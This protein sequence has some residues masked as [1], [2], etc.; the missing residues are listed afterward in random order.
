MNKPVLINIVSGKGGTGKSLLSALLARMIAQEGAKVLL[1]DF[2]LFVRGLSHFYYLFVKEKR[3]ITNKKTISDYYEISSNSTNIESEDFAKERFYEVDILPAVSEIEEQLDYLEIE[4][5][6]VEK[7][8]R[9]L[10]IL[11][12]EPYDYVIIDNR[13]GVDE[14][15]LETSRISELTITV[16]ESDPISKTTNENLLRHLSSHKVGKVYTIINKMKFIR[17]VEEYETSIE[18]IRSDFNVI[19][20]IPFDV[21]LFEKFGTTRFWDIAN[22]T[23]YAYALGETWNKLA[24]RE[25]YNHLIDMNRFPKNEIWPGGMKIPAFFNKI[26]RMSILLSIICFFGYFLFDFARYQEF[27]T[28]DIFLVYGLIMLAIPVV[29]R[30]FFFDKDK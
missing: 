26:E 1:V 10:N 22:S 6:T 15:I 2:D 27:R 9:L 28:K 23:R 21:D 17:S 13:A 20:Q 8:K 30:L 18:H 24:K 4:K 25:S 11:K 14:L 3:K 19:G 29:R 5:E 7:T 16:S 12:K